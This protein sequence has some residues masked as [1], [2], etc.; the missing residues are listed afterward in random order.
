MAFYLLPVE[1]VSKASWTTAAAGLAMIGA[2]VH[3][4][5]SATRTVDNVKIAARSAHG[6]LSPT[7]I[8]HVGRLGMTDP[9]RRR[10]AALV[11]GGA[12]VVAHARQRK[13]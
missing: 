10:R 3:G 13:D 12:L 6:A 2:G 1:P 11:G 9:V 4:T 7:V 5:R 8:H